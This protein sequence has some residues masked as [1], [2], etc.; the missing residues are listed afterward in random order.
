MTIDDLIELVNRKTDTINEIR[1]HNRD[2]S[3]AIHEIKGIAYFENQIRNLIHSRI[4][5]NKE[6]IKNL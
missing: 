4:N 2:L 1:L 6:N 3:I 5:E